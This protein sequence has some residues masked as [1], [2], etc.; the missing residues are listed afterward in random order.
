LTVRVI[1]NFLPA[2]RNGRVEQ[3]VEQGVEQDVEQD[4]EQGLQMLASVT[5]SRTMHNSK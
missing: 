2:A 1:I 4:V 5:S 3:G